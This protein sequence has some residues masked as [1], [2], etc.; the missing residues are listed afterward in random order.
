MLPDMMAGSTH[1]IRIAISAAGGA[2]HG[3]TRLRARK[4]YRVAFLHNMARNCS[5]H[6]K[7]VKL[8]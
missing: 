1:N 5:Q 6:P 4:R 2:K 7:I 8:T 3:A